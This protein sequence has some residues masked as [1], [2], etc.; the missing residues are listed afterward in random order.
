MCI[1]PIKVS[2][3]HFCCFLSTR[4]DVVVCKKH[5]NLILVVKDP[6]KKRFEDTVVASSYYSTHRNE[7]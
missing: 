1:H 5:A 3:V 2:H 6:L 4:R 7:A